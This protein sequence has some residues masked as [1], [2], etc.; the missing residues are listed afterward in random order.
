MGSERSWSR[1]ARARGAAVALGAGLAFPGGALLMVAG[2]GMP[3]A[4]QPP[5][6]HLPQRVSD[7]SA[8][9]VGDQ[10]T[11]TWTM[12]R[13]NTDKL[14][15]KDPIEARVCRRES[16][17]GVCELAGKVQFAPGGDATF[18]E[19]LP[20]ALAA[21]APRA[22]TY[23][24]ELDNA[25]G[26]SAGLSNA[27]L[28]PAGAAPAAVE[29]L[30][31]RMRRDGV[32]LAWTPTAGEGAQEGS[33]VRLERTLLTPAKKS[34]EKKGASPLAAPP[35]AV[36]QNLLVAVGG[37]AGN[38][39][40]KDIRFG[41]SYGYRAERVAQVMVG[42][43]KLELDGPL[44]PPVR[45]DAVQEFPPAVPVGLAA[46]ATAG[47]SGAGANAG[48]AAS[49]S[50]ISGPAIDLSWQP[51]T[52]TDLAGYVVYR[53]DVAAATDASTTGEAAETYSAAASAAW[54]RISGA[55]PVV[56]PGFH[57]AHVEAGHTY[58]YAV[59]AIDQEGHESAR[60][61]EAQETV[62]AP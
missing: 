32:L 47:E 48:P 29:G 61:V 43:E 55:Q 4:P 10:V 46:V 26:R 38:A 23:L 40:D 15:L 39:L 7:L 58:A 33:A 14:L 53:R 62:P 1:W 17:A 59:S 30:N 49:G 37:Q 11:L 41:E 31:A 16:A 54:E 21:G 50:A 52:E 44:S 8:S 6:L 24:V 2:C 45:I 9:R 5:S 19:T 22:L 35:E 42:G 13:C 51:N 3:G 25:R 12:P 57:D 20:G 60:S 18:S 36:E 34:E 56:G 28:V 27:A